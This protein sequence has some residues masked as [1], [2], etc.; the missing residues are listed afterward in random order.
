MTKSCASCE[1]SQAVKDALECRRRAPPAIP[2]FT[3]TSGSANW[4]RV[5]P[6]DWCGD[7]VEL[8]DKRRRAA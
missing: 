3:D 7:Y 4:P 5:Q 1:F 2:F 8:A 6:T